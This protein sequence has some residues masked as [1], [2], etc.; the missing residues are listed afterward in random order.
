V[1]QKLT[2]HLPQV[3]WQNR[4]IVITI[5]GCGGTGSQIATGMPYLHQALLASGHPT[6]CGYS[7]LMAIGSLKQT[8]CGSHSVARRWVFTRP[9]S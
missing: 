7:W 1:P 3:N 6:G 4:R 2:E 8:A 5:V 9:W